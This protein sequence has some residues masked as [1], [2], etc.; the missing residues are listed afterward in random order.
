[1]ELLLNMQKCEVPIRRESLRDQA[2]DSIK[3]A[4]PML[5]KACS[6][7]CFEQAVGLV[8]RQQCNKQTLAEAGKHSTA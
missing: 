4:A 2:A 7:P 6:R 3:V 1:V 5:A 8:K